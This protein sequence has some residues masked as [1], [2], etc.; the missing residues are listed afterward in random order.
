MNRVFKLNIV[1]LITIANSILLPNA[2]ANP[3]SLTELLEI[4]DAKSP[5]IKGAYGA[6]KLA[7]AYQEGTQNLLPTNPEIE[8]A[9]G[10]RSLQS[11][12]GVEV[13]IGLQQEFE[14]AG[15]TSLRRTYAT[16]KVQQTEAE[17]A[18]ARWRVHV[19]VHRLYVDILLAEERV[20][21]AERFVTHALAVRDVVLKQIEVGEDS[22]LSLLVAEADL[23][24]T[25]EMEVA[26]RQAAESFRVQLATTIGWEEAE[27]PEV[28]GEVPSVMKAPEVD[29][30]LR[31]LDSS[32]PTMRVRE[33]AWSA[34]QTQLE[35]ENR[36]LWPNPRL[37]ISY[38]RESA[39][40]PDDV[41]HIWM[42]NL[43][44]EI[45]T[46]NRN[47]EGRARAQAE[48]DIAHQERV[49]TRLKLQTEIREKV[50]SLNAAARRVAIY[51]EGVIPQLEK[52]LSLLQRAWDLGEVDIHQVSQM[53]ES[54]L[55]ASA[56][57]M[58]ALVTYFDTA[59][60]LEG[61]AG[62]EIW[63]DS[64]DEK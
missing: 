62:R 15:Q 27:L 26:A 59:A 61:L 29:E 56:Q 3:L 55:Q 64:E 30:L 32:H 17:L 6:K 8:L 2:S 18:E 34:S 22:P 37:G 16:K 4:A 52:N 54:L 14:I 7:E 42:L 60:A 45:P 20:L 38:A 46:W 5:E 11:D 50:N 48:I 41:S 12:M 1:L 25:R 13:Q 63:P 9:V 23:A 35:L 58:N 31:H 47:E 53:R 40:L 33:E 51:E 28:H 44:I 39:L 43:A 10:G 57:H 49:A 21:Q 19:E 24:R 36:V